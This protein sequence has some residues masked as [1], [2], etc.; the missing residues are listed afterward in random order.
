M[1]SCVISAQTRKPQGPHQ[2]E[3]VRLTV[4]EIVV[5]YFCIGRARKEGDGVCSGSPPTFMSR[6]A[7]TQQRTLFVYIT[8][9]IPVVMNILAKLWIVEQLAK[10]AN[11]RKVRKML[12]TRRPQRMVV[13]L[14]LRADARSRHRSGEDDA[15]HQSGIEEEDEKRIE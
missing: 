8:K 13:P 12:P 14:A 10:P 2:L 11:M 9:I 7:A 4:R 3:M 5:T 15:A 1:V 6:Q